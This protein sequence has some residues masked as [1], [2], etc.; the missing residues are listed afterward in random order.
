MKVTDQVP[1][2]PDQIRGCERGKNKA[3]TWDVQ[4]LRNAIR[5]GEPWYA[6]STDI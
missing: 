5:V 2:T 6:P 3:L 4:L 1:A